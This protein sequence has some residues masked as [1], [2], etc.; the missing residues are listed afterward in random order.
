MCKVDDWKPIKYDQDPET[1]M[2]P[3]EY[4]EETNF[5]EI[6]ISWYRDN[7]PLMLFIKQPLYHAG[8]KSPEMMY[9]EYYKDSVSPQPS[10][11]RCLY[12]HYPPAPYDRPLRGPHPV[13]EAL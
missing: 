5:V 1:W 9:E 11:R 6:P 2:T 4:G 3:Y 7:I 13:R 8:Y 12:V 10:Q